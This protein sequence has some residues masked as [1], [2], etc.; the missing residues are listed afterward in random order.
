MFKNSRE[1]LKT[2]KI[3]KDENFSRKRK[4]EDLEEDLEEEDNRKKKRK[5]NTSNESVTTTT[6]DLIIKDIDF[7]ATRVENDQNPDEE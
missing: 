5:K 1:N 4:Q 7:V 3:G 2:N 6:T